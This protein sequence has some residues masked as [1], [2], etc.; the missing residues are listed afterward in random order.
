VTAVHDP[1]TVGPAAVEVDAPALA[2]APVAP[3]EGNSVLRRRAEASARTS[4]SSCSAALAGLA[5]QMVRVRE[6]RIAT[7]HRSSFLGP[8]EETRPRTGL[9]W[10]RAFQFGELL[11]RGRRS[12]LCRLVDVDGQQDGLEIRKGVRC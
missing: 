6:H 5:R 4:A 3:G 10:H 11:Q 1:S 8:L 2:P 9:P 7:G 12:V